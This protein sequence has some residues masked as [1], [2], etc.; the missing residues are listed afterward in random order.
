[1][2]NTLLLLSG[3]FLE[4]CFG[5][6]KF[7]LKYISHPVIWIGKLIKLID[8]KL[9]K[10]IYSHK[11]KKKLGILSLLL[12]IMITLFFFQ[13]ITFIF[14]NLLYVEFFY[15]FIIWSLMCS[16][17]LYSHIINILNNL[18]K[19]DIIKAK[20]SLS[21]VV[22]RDTA[23]LK[24]K[25]IVRASLESL[26]ENTSDAI[27]APIF[28]YFLFGIH[29]LIIF[30][31]INTLDSMI[32]YKSKKYLAFGYASA[33][34]DD[35]LNIIPSRLTGLVFVLL[36][37]KPIQTFRVMM[38]NASKSPS[39]NAGWPESAFA[40]A[41][42]IRLGGPKTYNGISNKDKWLNGEYNDPTVNDF[43][44][45]IKLYIKSVIFI[46]FIIIIFTIFNYYIETHD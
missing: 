41:L 5:W 40:G 15:I 22:G 2:E 36:S 16:R 23:N 27:V 33:K 28:W 3:I 21:K 32:G 29:G 9:N 25:A 24:K 7:F 17:S 35:I 14:H 46:I 6:P 18:E 4:I 8:V 42:S 44:E 12:T 45:G 20:K 30:K 38:K 31:T 19:N 11:I 26:S 1:M 43:Y 10:K 39:P 37:S 34:I 13:F